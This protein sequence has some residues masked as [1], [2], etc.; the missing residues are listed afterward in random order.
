MNSV[1]FH[2]KLNALNGAL[3]ES[4]QKSGVETVL[5]GNLFYDHLESDFQNRPLNPLLETKRQRLAELAKKCS[6]VFEVGVNGGHSGFLMLYSNPELN[7]IGNDIAAYYPP[8]PR[9]HPEVYVPAAFNA[10]KELFP[11][12]VQTITGDCLIELPEYA[13]HNNYPHIDLLHLDG[14]KPTYERDFFTML[15]LLKTNAYI[16]FDDT[17]QPDVQSLVDKL[18]SKNIVKRCEYQKMSQGE[19]YSHEIVQLV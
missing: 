14:H 1:D 4:L 12:R 15:P 5:I 11:G 2:G 6:S 16:V 13:K 8:E 19:K 7:Y 3:V 9:C 18:L 10:L 17:Q